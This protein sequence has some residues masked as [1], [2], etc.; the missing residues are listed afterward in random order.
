VYSDEPP[1]ENKWSISGHPTE[2][3]ERRDL[4][5]G[6]GQPPAKPSSGG[7]GLWKSP[8]FPRTKWTFQNPM[9]ARTSMMGARRRIRHDTHTRVPDDSEG[10]KA[11]SRSDAKISCCGSEQSH[12]SAARRPS[13]LPLCF[14]GH[15][16]AAA[17]RVIKTQWHILGRQVPYR[18]ASPSLAANMEHSPSPRRSTSVEVC[19]GF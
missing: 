8:T 19:V 11:A 2:G 10:A 5:I 9:F 3:R 18:K 1:R 15:Q 17:R 13:W 4:G 7:S 16:P 12:L 6:N 14:C